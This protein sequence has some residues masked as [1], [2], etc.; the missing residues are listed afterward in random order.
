MVLQLDTASI[1]T[2]FGRFIGHTH[3]TYAAFTWSFLK[4]S[5]NIF[6]SQLKLAIQNKEHELYFLRLIFTITFLICMIIND[7]IVIFNTLCFFTLFSALLFIEKN[8]IKQ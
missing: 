3:F 6:Y 1:Y 2:T 7:Y 4:S 5:L 8:T